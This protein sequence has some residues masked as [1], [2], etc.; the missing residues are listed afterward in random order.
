MTAGVSAHDVIGSGKALKRPQHVPPNPCTAPPPYVS[1][2]RR[3]FALLH[4]LILLLKEPPKTGMHARE[5]LLT[6][7]MVQ[8]VRITDYLARR[9][10]IVQDAVTALADRFNMLPMDWVRPLLQLPQDMPPC[11]NRY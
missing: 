1:R 8:D 10:F 4:P 3:Q 5:A 6:A 2:T 7:M 11:C 9:T